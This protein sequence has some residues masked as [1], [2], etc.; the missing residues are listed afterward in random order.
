MARTAIEVLLMTVCAW[1]ET[2][3][4]NREEL[5]FKVE[6]MSDCLSKIVKHIGFS[7]I[8]EHLS[9]IWVLARR[10]LCIM[11]GIAIQSTE[12]ITVTSMGA[13]NPRPRGFK[14][15]RE[16]DCTILRL[17]VDMALSVLEEWILACPPDEPLEMLV[18]LV[19]ST[20]EDIQCIIE[21]QPN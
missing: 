6:G 19:Q 16:L 11:R 20:L 3:A 7:S 10:V 5:L 21:T 12:S 9:T 2:D 4:S 1:L 18:S 17:E 13:I 8:T 14:A 15:L